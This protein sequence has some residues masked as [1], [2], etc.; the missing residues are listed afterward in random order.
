MTSN[1]ANHLAAELCHEP[2]LCRGQ[3][4]SPCL[5]SGS[6]AVAALSHGKRLV[7]KSRIYLPK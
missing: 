2:E 4:A 3:A 1:G 7:R 6:A 5:A